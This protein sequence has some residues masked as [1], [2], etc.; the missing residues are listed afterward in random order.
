M[1]A[2]HMKKFLDQMGIHF[3]W[4]MAAIAFLV[5][6]FSSASLAT[7]GILMVEITKILAGRSGTSPWLSVFYF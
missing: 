7:P 5:I 6:F 1:F 4:F 2:T 3:S